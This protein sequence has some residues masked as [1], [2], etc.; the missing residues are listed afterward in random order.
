M[1]SETG[2]IVHVVTD[3]IPDCAKFTL[4]FPAQAVELGLSGLGCSSGTAPSAKTFDLFQPGFPTGKA[5]IKVM[6]SF[7]T[8]LLKTY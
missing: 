4:Q 5:E 1:Q 2:T 8:S 7:L 6:L 3:R